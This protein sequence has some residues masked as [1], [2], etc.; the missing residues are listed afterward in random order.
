MIE[1]DDQWNQTGTPKSQFTM[2]DE[3]Y[4]QALQE[5]VSAGKNTGRFTLDGSD[6]TF[7]IQPTTAGHMLVFLDITARQEILTNLNYTFTIVGVVMLIILY[8]TN[9]VFCQPLHPVGQRSL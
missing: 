5:A 8:F 3:F 7:E 9:A 2:E 6:W 1:T 4:Q